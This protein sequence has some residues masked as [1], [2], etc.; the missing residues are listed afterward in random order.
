MTETKLSGWAEKQNGAEEEPMT[1]KTDLKKLFNQNARERKRLKLCLTALW[2]NS[3]PRS[4]RRAER[5]QS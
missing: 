2:D 1:L 4:P 3:K 5:V